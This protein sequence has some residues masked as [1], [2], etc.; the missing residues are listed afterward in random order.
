LQATRNQWHVEG[1]KGFGG[2]G[3]RGQIPKFQFRPDPLAK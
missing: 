3:V 2:P 1:G